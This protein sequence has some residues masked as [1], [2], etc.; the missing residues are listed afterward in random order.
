MKK[1]FFPIAAAFLVLIGSAAAQINSTITVEFAN[2]ALM[3]MEIDR[4]SISVQLGSNFSS[5]PVALSSPVMITIKSNVSWMLTATANSDFIGTDNT[6]NRISCSQLEFKSRLSGS[7]E[8]VYEQ[9]DE[10]L[11]FAKSQAMLLARGG[12]TPNEGLHILVEYRLLVNL[13]DPAGN[14]SLPIIFTLNPAQ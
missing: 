4:S 3:S 1:I 10:F 8:S 11:G 7:T 9:Q 2:P 6:S 12:A 5:G 13:K 14:Y